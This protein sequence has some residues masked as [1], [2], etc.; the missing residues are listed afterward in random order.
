MSLFEAPLIRPH[1][2][3]HHAGE[4]EPFP[5]G[6]LTYL[7]P[8]PLPTGALPMDYSHA[9]G[10]MN[11]RYLDF[12]I[13]KSDVFMWQMTLFVPFGMFLLCAI[14]FPLVGM[15]GGFHF[16]NGWPDAIDAFWGVLDI[17]FWMGLW[18]GL[19]S[20]LLF[21]VLRWQMYAK[22]ERIGRA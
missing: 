21:M 15:A 17:S 14:V 3:P 1:R 18:G 16:G 2:K 22:V 7:A 12:G 10:V 9:V 6:H 13:G 8:K 20:L 19:A 5:T 11:D 4:I